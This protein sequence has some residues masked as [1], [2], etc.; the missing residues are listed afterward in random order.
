MTRTRIP[1]AISV[2][3]S[4]SAS[5]HLIPTEYI[6]NAERIYKKGT[7]RYFTLY[8]TNKCLFSRRYRCPPLGVF[9]L[10]RPPTQRRS[11]RVR[12][13]PPLLRLL[14]SF[15]AC[16]R[17]GVG[18]VCVPAKDVLACL[19][20]R[21][22]YVCACLLTPVCGACVCVHAIACCSCTVS[23]LRDFRW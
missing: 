11:E 13:G 4:L 17:V 12:Q 19:V 21:D 20:Q 23:W 1:Y 22:V 5:K 9:R 2:S 14:G 10:P 7:T 18:S 15:D 8:S 3:P 6:K 16:A